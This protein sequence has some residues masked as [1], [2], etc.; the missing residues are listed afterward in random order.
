MAVLLRDCGPYVFCLYV[1]WLLLGDFGPY[2]FCLYV[3]WLLLRD[4]GPYG[5]VFM[6]CFCHVNA[7]N[8]F[9][10]L[11]DSIYGMCLLLFRFSLHSWPVIY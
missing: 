10:P 4:F 7:V 8:W 5:M 3:G 11:Q 9:G 1:S 2:V 6:M